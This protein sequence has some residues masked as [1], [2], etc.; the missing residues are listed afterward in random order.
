MKN[1][2]TFLRNFSNA[3]ANMDMETILDAVTDDF[4]FA[5]AN[6]DEGVVG[7]AAFANWLKNMDCGDGNKATIKHR[8]FLLDGTRAALTGNMEVVVEGKTERFSFCDL[9]EL[10]G[11]KIKKL[12]AY[13]MKHGEQMGCPSD[14]K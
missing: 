6:C 14:N 13:F 9:Y 3:W 1:T 11:S 7:K 12:T 5:M 4:S 2:E 8:D 10:E